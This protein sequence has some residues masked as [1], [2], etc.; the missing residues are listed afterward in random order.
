M[1][2]NNEERNLLRQRRRYA[3]ERRR[4][5]RGYFLDRIRLNRHVFR[6]GKPP[7]GSVIYDEYRDMSGAN[8]IFKN[9][10][11]DQFLTVIRP[12]ESGY[13]EIGTGAYNTKIPDF[14]LLAFAGRPY[15][16][17]FPTIQAKKFLVECFKRA[18][19][20]FPVEIQS[21]SILSNSAYLVVASF[22]QTRVS[23]QRFLSSVIKSY[24]DY[25]N[26][27]FDHTGSPFMGRPTIKRLGSCDD[28][29]EKIVLAERQPM[30]RGIHGTY[31]F[32]SLGEGENGI[33]SRTAFQN[34]FGAEGKRELEE[35]SDEEFGRLHAVDLS[36]R[37]FGYI[38]I[39][40]QAIEE[41]L[42]DFGCFTKRAIPHDLMPKIIAE[43]VERTRAPYKKVIK[44]LVGAGWN[45]Q[46]ELLI[47]TIA[48]MIIG[49][50]HTFDYAWKRLRIELLQK[51]TVAIDVAIL[52]FERLRYS[53]DQI[54]QMMGFAYAAVIGGKVEYYNDDFLVRVI[55]DYAAATKT[56]IISVI[57][58]FGIR[59]SLED[60]DRVKK[61][62]AYFM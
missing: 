44:K 30:V 26:N 15:E 12:V 57:D 46:Y 35:A 27:I 45:L 17:V 51:R 56:P 58:A 22:D 43:S 10:K 4:S 60:P 14:Y 25:Y 34:R 20:L 3:E 36:T 5:L 23:V 32:C 31:Q 2:R 49:D 61:V 8:G 59:N 19:P 40:D 28:I 1:A 54:F 55:K 53:I 52:M 37:L 50:R 41:V 33:T 24:V 7:K 38:P 48:E 39:L 42:I 16:P 6:H 62:A 11:Q 21:Y 47:A 13:E 9:G 29:A 18:L